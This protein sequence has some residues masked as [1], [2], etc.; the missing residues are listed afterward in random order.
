[1]GHWKQS[2]SDKMPVNRKE[3][4]KTVIGL[5]TN[6][7]ALC[8]ALS[9]A[10]SLLLDR[11]DSLTKRIA[12]L[13]V[14]LFEQRCSLG[15]MAHR[16]PSGTPSRSLAPNDS[17]YSFARCLKHLRELAPS[18]CLEWERLLAENARAYSGY[19]TDSCSVPGH[20]MAE[21]FRGFLRPYLTGSVLDIGC[22]PQPVPSY[23]VGHPTNWIAGVD[24][25]P[26]NHPFVFVHGTA[27]FL[28]WA[29][30]T[31]DTVVVAT[32]LDHLLLL[33]RSFGEI[34]R[35]LKPDGRFVTWVSFVPGAAPYDP[36]RPDSKPVDEFHLFHFD[37]PGF[38]KA[39]SAD[40]SLFEMVETTGSTFVGLRPRAQ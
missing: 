40:F 5:N 14:A 15:D 24:P 38:D 17:E 39:I 16:A 1:M 29:D 36:Y 35:V 22:G 34:R 3:Y 19:P 2:L 20:P 30:A 13:E 27:E 8:D 33:D 32:S 10:Q 28:P 7:A 25:L 12:H 37:R 23:L 18:A 21:R 11:T 31:F 26:A 9:A 4:T 6:L